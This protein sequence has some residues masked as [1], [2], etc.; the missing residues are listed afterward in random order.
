MTTIAP[1]LPHLDPTADRCVAGFLE[2]LRTNQAPSGLFA[3][4]M[5]S[6]LTFPCWRVQTATADDATA[7]RHS[8]HPVVGAVRLE[9]LEPTPSGVIMQI[10]E[11]WSDADQ[12]WYCREMFRLTIR[13]GLI[14]EL[15]LYCTGDWDEVTQ[16]RH[17]EEVTLIRT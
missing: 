8:G 4:D 5:F 11:H 1:T 9:H 13:D 12:L 2:F 3:P 16:R 6:D 15:V 17:A 14:V 10:E 7:I